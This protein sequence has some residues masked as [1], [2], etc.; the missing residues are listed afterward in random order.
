MPER[1]IPQ[2]TVVVTEPLEGS[3]VERWGDMIAA[4]AALE[5]PLLVVDLSGSPRIDA[6]AIVMLLQTH[7]AM[8]CADGRLLLRGASAQVRR[9][10]G[11]A[12]VDRVLDVEDQTGAAP[13]VPTAR[14]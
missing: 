1:T 5:P 2:T 8:V 4:A 14:S 12:R 3:A 11:L 6:S 7:R 10:L 13:A 9:M